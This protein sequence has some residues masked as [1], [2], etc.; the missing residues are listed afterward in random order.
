TRRERQ[1][2]MK[3]FFQFEAL[4]TN[5]KREVMAGL[6]T[7]LAMAYILFVNPSTLGLVVVDLPAGVEGMD[8]GAVFTAT[9]IAAAIG[10]LFM[11]VIA[12]YPIVLAPGIGLSAFFAYT[13]VLGY[14]IPWQTALSGVLVSGL[15][16]ILLTL[17]GLREKIINSI[18][19][20]LKLAVGVGIGFFI[21]F[22]GLKNAGIIVADETTFVA[23]GDLT[24][25]TVLLAVFGLV[26]SIILLTLKFQGGIFYGMLLTVVAGMVT[27]LIQTPRHW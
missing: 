1:S 15:I 18:T 6:T 20:N 24:T 9:A 14:G 26:V 3:K 10:S 5:Y 17:T 11:G 16:F 2:A 27:G 22:I 8:T 12:K 25:P 23:I 7:F 19:E 21:A 13:V 4:G